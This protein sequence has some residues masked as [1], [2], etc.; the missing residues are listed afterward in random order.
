M[1]GKPVALKYASRF[2]ITDFGEY[3][4]IEVF[5]PWAGSTDT[6]SYFIARD[7]R[8]IERSDKGYNKVKL[9]YP[10]NEVVCFSTTHLPYLEFLDEEET[11]TGFPTTEYISSE[12]F[13]LRVR[14]GLIEDLGPSNE[15]N[16]EKLLNL[17]PGLVVAFT[18][19]NDL[20][21]IK[22][23]RLS[24]IPV[25]LNADY[26]EK[27]P[28]GR[29]EWIKF[30]AAFFNKEKMAD[31]IFN[32]IEKEYVATMNK[33]YGIEHRPAVFTGVVYGDTWFMPGG[34][35]YGSIFFSDAGARYLWAD[36]PSAETLKIGFESVYD[37]AADADFWVGTATYTSLEEIRHADQRYSEFRAF[38]EGNVYNYTARAGKNGGNPYFELGYARP[39]I[40]L[41]DLT[42]IFH[43]SLMTGHQFY[44]YEKLY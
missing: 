38:K 7:K 24:G 41:K 31:S 39:D 42:K 6:F 8:D 28:L 17:D 23:I 11:L 10:V 44:F 26:L 37:K 29:A 5:S 1:E 27:H 30:M 19:G 15:I 21:F 43:P 25:V 9:T 12:V 13:R 20:S 35:H 34:N 16:I 32:F 14:Q 2:S 36:N 3:K 40:I 33:T 18:M 22:K 4:R